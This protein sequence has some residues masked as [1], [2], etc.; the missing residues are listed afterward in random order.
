M[1]CSRCGRE[2]GPTTH[3]RETEN[4]YR[5]DYYRL[6]TGNLER[7]AIQNPRD[8]TEILEFYKL[9]DPRFVVTC[10]DC[11]RLPGVEEE[12]EAL[13]SGVPDNDG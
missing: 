2:V 1:R 9:N 8:E 6:L 3:R 7:V 13:F 11:L 12:L 4:P 5:V 10:A